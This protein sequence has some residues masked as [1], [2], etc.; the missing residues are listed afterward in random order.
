MG[1]SGPDWVWGEKKRK[2]AFESLKVFYLFFI[3]FKRVS[4]Y[5]IRS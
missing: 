1:R 4:T 3:F 5:S 2:E